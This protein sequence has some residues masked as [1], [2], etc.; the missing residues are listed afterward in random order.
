MKNTREQPI[1][2]VVEE[3][4]P[5]STEEKIKVNGCL[6]HNF[7][8]QIITTKLLNSITNKYFFS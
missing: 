5:L 4:F 8:T 7:I 3:Q 6:L 2:I 1:L